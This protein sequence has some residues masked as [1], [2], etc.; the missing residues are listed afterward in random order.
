MVVF[1]PMEFN[2]FPSKR[3]SFGQYL[4]ITIKSIM[5]KVMGLGIVITAEK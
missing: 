3:F 4:P 2:S 5:G 1:N